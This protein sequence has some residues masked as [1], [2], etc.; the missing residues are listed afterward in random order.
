[1]ADDTPGTNGSP[2]A[3][4]NG[5]SATDAPPKWFQEFSEKI[6]GQMA[7]VFSRIGKMNERLKPTPEGT[8][9]AN[10][11]TSPPTDKA[12]GEGV[13]R[14]EMRAQVSAA[15]KLGELRGRLPEEARKRLDEMIEA[16]RS[17]AEAAEFAEAI[18]TFAPPATGTNGAPAVKGHAATAAPNDASGGWPTSISELKKLAQSNPE[19]YRKLMDPKHPFDPSA[20]SQR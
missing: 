18:V 6:G 8:N 16:G 4:G 13:S 19:K 9:G 17:Y 7:D 14:D 5:T 3:T 2:P 1:M 10:G 12:K 11:A 15:M 20:I